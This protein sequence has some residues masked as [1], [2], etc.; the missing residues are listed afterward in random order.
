MAVVGDG[1]VGDVAPGGGEESFLLW[2]VDLLGVD[3]E[4][5]LVNAGFDGYARGEGVDLDGIL[6]AQPEKLVEW[7]D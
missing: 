7:Y 6:G 1:R 5:A 2:V 4:A 3:H